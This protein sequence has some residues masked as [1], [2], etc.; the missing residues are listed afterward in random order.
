MCW[1]A[2]PSPARCLCH[3]SFNIFPLSTQLT[4]SF[5]EK[6]LDEVKRLRALISEKISLPSPPPLIICGPSGVGKGTLLKHLMSV[7][8][9]CFKFSV[10]HTTRG[11]R[12][13]EVNG[14]DYNFTAVEEM[15]GMIERG[16]FLEHAE[17]HGNYY[18]TS[19]E[20]LRVDNKIVILDIDVQGVKKVK[21]AIKDKKLGGAKY[22][23]IRPKDLD[24]L[25]ARLRGRG[26]EKEEDIVRR[27]ANAKGEMEY[28]EEEGNF[29]FILVNDDLEVAQKE[30]VEGV[31]ELYE[32]IML[33]A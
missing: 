8:P 5:P 19:F 2:S 6:A 20:A 32:T 25:E 27:T 7:I 33:M 4:Q 22:V 1:S 15:K 12:D 11:P 21:E 9:G 14:V 28:S 17:V 26:T 3:V 31:K 29:D 10:S 30:L 23:F 16:E 13:G 18:G 24:S